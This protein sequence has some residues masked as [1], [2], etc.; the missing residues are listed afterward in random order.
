MTGRPSPLAITNANAP[1][2]FVFLLELDGHWKEALDDGSVGY[3][4]KGGLCS[5]EK[6]STGENHRQEQLVCKIFIDGHIC[7]EPEFGSLNCFVSDIFCR[8]AAFAKAR[9]NCDHVLCF[10]FEHQS[11]SG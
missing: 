4:V 5:A 11:V 10:N 7:R 2:L 1:G 8:A 9:K 3:G 6:S